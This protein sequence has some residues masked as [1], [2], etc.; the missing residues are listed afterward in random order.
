MK[1][2]D[3]SWR[4]AARGHG[5]RHVR[6]GRCILSHEHAAR[7]FA[8]LLVVVFALVS[9]STGTAQSNTPDRL[10]KLY[11]LKVPDRQEPSAPPAEQQQQPAGVAPSET[12]SDGDR[13]DADPSTES[14]PQLVTAAQLV[15]TAAGI[16]L[17]AVGLLLLLLYS[18]GL[19]T[20]RRPTK[21]GRS[22]ES[23]RGVTLAAGTR[24]MTSESAGRG[25]KGKALQKGTTEAAAKS[26]GNAQEDDGEN[27]SQHQEENEISNLRAPDLQEAVEEPEALSVERESEQ[28]LEEVQAEMNE[29]QGEP[30][31][32]TEDAA[33]RIAT[34]EERACETVESYAKTAKDSA[35]QA[36]DETLK[37]LGEHAREANSTVE[38]E[39]ERARLV[40]ENGC[41]EAKAAVIE[42]VEQALAVLEDADRTLA[43]RPSMGPSLATRSNSARSRSER[44]LLSIDSHAVRA[45]A[46]MSA[47]GHESIMAI[48]AQTGEMR[49]L[50]DSRLERTAASIEAAGERARAAIHAES[51]NALVAARTEGGLSD[52]DQVA[53]SE[54]AGPAEMTT[55]ER[56]IRT[57][58]EVATAA[59]DAH[60]EEA[61][62]TTGAAAAGARS[63][64]Q[65]ETERAFHA[66]R[67][68]V[69][70]TAQTV[71]ALVDE[72]REAVDA[73]TS[74]VASELERLRRVE[75][76]RALMEEEILR[77]R[78]AMEDELERTI[79]SIEV[80][81]EATLAAMST[82][83]APSLSDDPSVPRFQHGERPVGGSEAELI[84]DLTVAAIQEAAE[85]T[86]E[87]FRARAGRAVEVVTAEI[88]AGPPDE[89]SEPAG[90]SA[91]GGTGASDKEGDSSRR[92]GRKR[93]RHGRP[94]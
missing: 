72:I 74:A 24:S 27:P 37:L 45:Q 78:A 73:D 15:V 20:P 40:V 64:I 84:E 70:G 83:G 58:I 53:P 11:P 67:E 41:E 52:G 92:L 71:H 7:Y 16:G 34:M 46:V 43:Y 47:D 38:A 50:T 22:I 75:H 88:T 61:R 31:Q 48:R 68:T 25:D 39:I 69:E 13:P 94:R 17:L 87:S 29:Q 6:L 57:H 82:Q 36:A 5:R 56:Q 44:A 1:K 19:P 60:A 51:A 12:R 4:D 49:A 33:P 91:S 65:A 76:A 10:W 77:T 54:S 21:R 62:S 55:L 26:P 59:I 89:M 86:T 81:V 90:T 66:I 9:A 80:T 79:A 2:Y 8:G 30:L 28:V 18:L 3:E 85:A 14:R 23:P 42:M 35:R 63:A 32:A 93:R